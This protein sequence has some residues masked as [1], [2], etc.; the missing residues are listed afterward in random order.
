MLS[1]PC[2][3]CLRYV[4]QLHSTFH[5]I[6]ANVRPKQAKIERERERE[7]ETDTKS[8]GKTTTATATTWANYK[9]KTITK[10]TNGI[11]SALHVG[12]ANALNSSKFRDIY[13]FTYRCLY[14]P[15][16]EPGEASQRQHIYCYRLSITFYIVA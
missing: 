8:N 5:T 11:S 6:R 16:E 12:V 15:I 3:L 13:T 1:V 14:A 10:Q 2:A 7:R 9:N 4:P